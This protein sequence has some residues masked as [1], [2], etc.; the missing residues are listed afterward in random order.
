MHVCQHTLHLLVGPSSPVAF[1]GRVTKI[2]HFIQ[3]G[4]HQRGAQLLGVCPDDLTLC[5]PQWLV[6][7]IPHGLAYSSVVIKARKVVQK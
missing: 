2:G 5:I 6:V 4:L 1:D 7:L 3:H